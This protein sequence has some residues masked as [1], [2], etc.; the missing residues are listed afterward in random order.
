MVCLTTTP[1][2]VHLLSVCSSIILQMRPISLTFSQHLKNTP[3]K[4]DVIPALQDVLSLDNNACN[5]HQ[6][7]RILHVHDDLLS[8]PLPQSVHLRLTI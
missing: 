2:V 7:D 6:Y 3:A 5:T 8:Q 4:P 1:T